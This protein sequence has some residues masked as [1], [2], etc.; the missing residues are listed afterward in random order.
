M[1][2]CVFIVNVYVSFSRVFIGGRL[3]RAHKEFGSEGE[4][5]GGAG[6]ATERD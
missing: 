5:D 4:G 2:V 6:E 1:C 3:P